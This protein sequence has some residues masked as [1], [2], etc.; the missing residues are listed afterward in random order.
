MPAGYAEAMSQARLTGFSPPTHDDVAAAERLVRPLA[1]ETP[2]LRND[3]L[4]ELAGAFVFLKP[5]CLQV[6]GSFKIR[7]ATN[8]LVRMNS[9]ER[10]RGVV[11][12]SSGNHAQGVARAAR[13]LGMP[14]LIV[15]PLDAPEVKI[16]GVK[17]DGAEIRLYDRMTESRE[18]IAGEITRER[19]A[20]LV[21]SYDDRHVI[22]GQGTA[23]LEF[24]RAMAADTPLDH[25]ICCAGGGGLMAGCALAFEGASPS[26]RLWTAEPEGFDDHRRSLE[27]GDI[28]TI[29]PAARSIC[30][31]ILTPQPGDLTFA[32]NR[33]RLSGGFAVTDDEVREA[34]RFA[35]R[36]LKLVVEPGGAVALAAAMFRLPAYMRGQRV[37]VMLSGGNVDPALFA[38][39]IRQA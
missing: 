39:I 4:D 12:F 23:G 33:I 2:V 25:F 36:H 5:E 13:V 24:A 16:D 6:T 17:A 9:D 34:M 28:R 30:D 15:M 38:D 1:I 27:A 35:F 37:G 32:I 22:A 29:D 20:V 7:G 3:A 8:R 10:R 19:G 18:T 26:T 14:A 21:P 11:A 31:A